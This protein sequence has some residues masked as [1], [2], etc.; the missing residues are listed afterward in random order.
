MRGD[1]HNLANDSSAE[2]CVDSERKPPPRGIDFESIELERH[3]IQPSTVIE[4]EV[5]EVTRES[6]ERIHDYGG[7]GHI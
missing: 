2:D 7:G 5:L 4:R 1:V 3:S 6:Q